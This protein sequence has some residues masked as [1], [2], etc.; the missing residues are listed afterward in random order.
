MTTT[1]LAR[2]GFG[3]PAPGA[4]VRLAEDLVVTWSDHLVT[5]ASP[6]WQPGVFVYDIE[7]LTVTVRERAGRR[8]VTLASSGAAFDFQVLRI[9]LADAQYA[10]FERLVMR[11]RAH[12]D[13]LRAAAG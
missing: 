4:R 11:V 9:D 6:R 12:R 2:G 7:F 10:Q 3:N 5:V 8:V 13:E 1:A